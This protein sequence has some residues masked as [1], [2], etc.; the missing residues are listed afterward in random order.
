ME[1]LGRRKRKRVLGDD[2]H[3]RL[4]RVKKWFLLF[5]L[6]FDDTKS[7]GYILLISSD[8]DNIPQVCYNDLTKCRRAET[9]KEKSI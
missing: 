5:N 4:E 2:Y 1:K 8:I 7:I 9:R 6:T 3:L